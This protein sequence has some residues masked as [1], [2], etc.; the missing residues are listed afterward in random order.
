MSLNVFWRSGFFLITAL[1]HTYTKSTC[2]ECP[3][4]RYVVLQETVIWTNVTY[5]KV[6]WEWIFAVYI[7]R[8]LF[9]II[10]NTYHISGHAIGHWHAQNRWNKRPFHKYILAFHDHWPRTYPHKEM[11]CRNY[12]S[13]Y[14]TGIKAFIGS[15]LRRQIQNRKWYSFS[16]LC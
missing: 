12:R 5:M 13:F 2:G 6:L 15:M 4:W 9:L 10:L 1:L 3:F 16:L 8:F 11:V 14:K 7:V